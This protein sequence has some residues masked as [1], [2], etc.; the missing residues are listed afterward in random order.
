MFT[1]SYFSYRNIVL[2]ISYKQKKISEM[3]FKSEKYT[4]LLLYLLVR[5][6]D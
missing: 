4:D 1:I 2:Y 5:Y 3:M 6:K